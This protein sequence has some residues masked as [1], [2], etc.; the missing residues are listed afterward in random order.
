MPHGT[1][2]PCWDSSE[3]TIGK[4]LALELDSISAIRNSFQTSTKLKATAPIRER[5]ATG[6]AI[7]QNTE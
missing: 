3:A 1:F 6:S 5:A 2:M 4:V 7:R